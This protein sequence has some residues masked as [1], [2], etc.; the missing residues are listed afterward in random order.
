MNVLGYNP[1]ELDVPIFYFIK[2]YFRNIEINGIKIIKKKC[3]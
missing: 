1:D 2:K 3:E